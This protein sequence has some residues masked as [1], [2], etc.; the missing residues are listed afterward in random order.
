MKPSDAKDTDAES[1]AAAAWFVRVDSGSEPAADAGLADWLAERPANERAMERVELA[2]E[3]GRRLAADPA[4]AL[5][6]EA[7]R[8]ARHPSRRALLATKGSL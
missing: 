7:A 3:L 6:A 4:H 2:V 8:A 1:D 5:H